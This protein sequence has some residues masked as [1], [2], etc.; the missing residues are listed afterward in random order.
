MTRERPVVAIDGPAGAGKSSVTRRVAA[1]L[2]YWI[3]DTGAIYRAVG[4]ATVRASLQASDA[5]RVTALAQA[6]A[7]RAAVTFQVQPD[8]TQLVCLDGEDVSAAIRSQAASSQASL[9]SA[10][11]G[12]RQALLAMQRE[13]GRSGGVVVEG[14][15][16]GSV[17]FPDAEVKFFLTASAEVRARRRYDELVARGEPADYAQVLSE[18][19]ERDERDRNRAVAPLIQAAD[20]RLVDSTAMN[21]EQVIATIVEQVQE[22]ALA[23]REQP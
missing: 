20:A 6:M 21:L 16:I 9:V 14:R 2:G 3:L 18:V 19:V 8:G 15:D 5:E 4:L 17:V 1:A 7:E 23:L 11:P 13:V 22:V 10:I 12:V